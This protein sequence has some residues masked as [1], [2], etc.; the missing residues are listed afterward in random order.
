M[1]YFILFVITCFL[2][3]TYSE[4]YGQVIIDAFGKV[5]TEKNFAADHIRCSK[6]AM[7][8]QSAPVKYPKDVKPA[9]PIYNKCM[10]K[11]NLK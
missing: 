4:V 7:K 10:E 6:E 9:A 1:R 8:A 5:V 3:L 11:W 2:Q